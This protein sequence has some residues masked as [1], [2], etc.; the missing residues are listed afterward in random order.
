MTPLEP[1]TSVLV[2]PAGP[3][4]NMAC[5]YCF[6]LNKAELFHGQRHRM[7]A[8]VQRAMIRETMRAAGKQVVFVWQG[9]EPTLMGHRFFER[10]VELQ[11]KFGRDQTVGNALQTNG[12]LLD[13]R[14]IRLFRRY[15]FLIGV[16]IDGPEEVHDHHRRRLGGQGSHAR[17]VAA[18]RRLLEA[19]VSTNAL[20]VVTDHSVKYPRQVFAHLR[21]LGLTHL[22]FIPCVEPANRRPDPEAY[23]AFL[24]QVFDLWCKDFRQGLPRATVRNFESL[25]HLYAGY[26]SPECT[27]M[28]ACGVYLVVEHDGSVYPCDF[29]VEPQWRL[30]D[31]TQDSLQALLNS[32]RQK[33][34]GQLK[35]QLC[36]SC[37][38]CPWVSYCRGGCT[39]HRPDPGELNLFCDAFQALFRH[40][41][42]RMER[43]VAQLGKQNAPV[44]AGVKVGR[45]A[46]CPCGSGKKFKRCCM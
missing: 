11:M 16:S 39:R 10:A 36:Q 45:N 38:V 32:Q 42:P 7:T 21:Q 13:E 4:C 14:W 17:A 8:E 40:A 30:G 6:Y 19:G 46:A 22:Q 26:P 25:L 15:R 12:L 27:L 29:Y 31:V 44:Q 23:G 43:M 41:E 1:L 2:K 3:D 35:A 28:E 37:Q 24:C 9:G 5:D 33:A 18:S 20:S 34:F